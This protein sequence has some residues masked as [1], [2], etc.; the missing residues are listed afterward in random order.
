MG[1]SG[2][3]ESKDEILVVDVQILS[4]MLSENGY[5]VEMALSGKKALEVVRRRLPDLIF[6]DIKMRGMSGYDV[7]EKPNSTRLTE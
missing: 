2:A 6:L 4:F 3:G 7:C 1:S 5:N